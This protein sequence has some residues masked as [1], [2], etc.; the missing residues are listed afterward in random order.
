MTEQPPGQ[1]FKAFAADWL[2]QVEAALEECLPKDHQPPQ[3]LHQAMRYA[4]FPGG[5]RLRPLLALLGCQATGGD[6]SRAMQP[7]AALELLHTYSLVHDDLPCMDDD[8]LRRGRPTVHKVYGEAMGVLVGDALLTLAFQAV[9]AGGSQAVEV[10]ALAA[11][12]L[13]MVGGQAADLAAEGQ[14]GQQGE[15]DDL[16]QLQWIHDHKT[17][18][19]IVASLLVGALA[20]AGAGAQASLPALRRYGSLVG[21]AFQVADD[22]LDLTAAVEDLGKQP[23]Q[24]LQA[25]KLT[26]PA[27]M[28]LSASLQEAQR[29]AQ[30]AVAEVPAIC[31]WSSQ[32][33][34]LDSAGALLQDVAVYTVARGS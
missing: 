31:S 28:G 10:L 11:G 2:P 7:A 8:D 27:V 14:L 29:L 24:D 16:Q 3:T 12:S 9:A 15:T 21:R 34:V 1:R 5:K 33:G 22:C 25:D 19:L 4:M 20:G 30:A 6:V 17:G 23:G 26:Y 18:D 32:A 13:G